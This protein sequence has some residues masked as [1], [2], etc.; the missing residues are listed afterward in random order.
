MLRHLLLV[1]CLTLALAACGRSAPYV[2]RPDE[3]NRESP[4][5]ALGQTDIS[6]VTICG[7]E[8]GTPSPTILELAG[9]ECAKFAKTAAFDSQDYLT[10]PLLSPVATHFS[11]L[12]GRSDATGGPDESSGW[13]NALEGWPY[14]GGPLQTPP[15][16]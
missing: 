3:F 1:L 5:F 7:S 8:S 9:A 10:C 15:R 16:Q 6:S 11:C 2:H 14:F 13:G 4:S 12:G